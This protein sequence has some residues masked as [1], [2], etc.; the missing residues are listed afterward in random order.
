ME[1]HITESAAYDLIGDSIIP[2]PGMESQWAD[3]KTGL[4]KSIEKYKSEFDYLD[5]S[6][7]INERMSKLCP[8]HPMTLSLLAT[9]AQ[10][11]GAS[12]RTLF[13]FMKDKTESS[14][15]VGFINYI[16]NNDP[17]DWGW[18]TADYLWDYFFT[19]GSDVRNFSAE[20][21]KVIQHFQNKQESI[22]D[23]YAMHVLRRLCSLSL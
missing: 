23:E 12:Q 15:G 16:E 3:T 11:F 5:Q 8:L 18:L 19:R 2:R 20:T 21:C 9:V 13:R 1:F 6:I 7:N 10:N 4:L 22:S 17:D 14:Q